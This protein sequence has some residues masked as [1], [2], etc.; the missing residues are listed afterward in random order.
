MICRQKSSCRV[1]YSTSSFVKRA[2]RISSLLSNRPRVR[3][4]SSR[5]SVVFPVPGSPAMRTIIFLLKHES[6]KQFRVLNRTACCPHPLPGDP[7][8][9][10]R[11]QERKEYAAGS[12]FTARRQ[13]GRIQKGPSRRCSPCSGGG[14][15]NS[16]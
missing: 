1:A 3:L 12:N 6:Q 16:A 14:D 4:A 7:E 10:V 8:C 15:R 9:P 5:A 13:D 11:E 2:W